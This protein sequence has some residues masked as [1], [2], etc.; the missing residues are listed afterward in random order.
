VANAQ[1]LKTVIGKRPWRVWKGIGSFLFFEFG[2][3]IEAPRGPAKGAFSIWIYMADWILDQNGKDIAHSESSERLLTSATRQLEGKKLNAITLFTEISR[4]NPQYAASFSFE[5]GFTLNAS[6]YDNGDP[7]DSIF[8]LFT[9]T[10]VVSYN[11]DGSLTDE[12][13]K[14]NQPTDPRP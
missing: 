14:P 11:Y 10:L 6:R 12:S 4:G 7:D 5:G 1:L 13:K 9:P 8:V 3:K 2:R